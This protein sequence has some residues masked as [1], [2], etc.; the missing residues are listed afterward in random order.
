VGFTDSTRLVVIYF[1]RQAYKLGIARFSRDRRV[2]L[3]N[4]PQ[5]QLNRSLIAIFEYSFQIGSGLG[6]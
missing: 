5:R 1:R 4:L 2:G 6:R 3:G